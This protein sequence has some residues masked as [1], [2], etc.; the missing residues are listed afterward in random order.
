MSRLALVAALVTALALGACTEAPDSPTGPSGVPRLP[1]TGGSGGATSGG[2]DDTTTTPPIDTTAAGDPVSNGTWTPPDST[3]PPTIV[4]VGGSYVPDGSGTA[5]T[6]GSST[7]LVFKTTGVGLYGVGTCGANGFWTDPAGNVFGP[8]NPN[9]LD[10]GSSGTGNK[11]LGQC[12][13]SASGQPGLWINPGGQVTHPFHSKCL[14]V[15]PTTTSLALSFLPQ[16]QLFAASDGSRVMNFYSA[17]IVVAQ[18]IYDGAS[19]TTTGAGIL[20]GKDNASP[21]NTWT[22]YFAQPALSYTSGLA[23]GDLIGGV[24]GSGVEVVACNTSI[25]CSLVTLKLTLAP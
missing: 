18:L 19:G 21:A 15:G 7:T 22:V 4:P 6:S 16:A 11:G 5:G 8:H 1:G 2:G 13:T 14:R 9:C 23:N 3:N 20:V 24:T 12:T 17:G 25:G 10:Y